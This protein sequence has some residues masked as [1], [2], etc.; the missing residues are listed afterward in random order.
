MTV[1]RLS[2]VL[3]LVVAVSGVAAG[4]GTGGESAARAAVRADGVRP[5]QGGGGRGARAAARAAQDPAAAN[6]QALAR[7]VRQAFNGVVRRELDLNDQKWRQ[8]QTVERRYQ[9]QKAQVQRDEKDARVGLKAAME[10]T[11]RTGGADQARISQYLDQLVQAQHRRAEL[12]DAEQKDLAS[13]LTPLQ[14]AK[15]QAL[16]EQ[17]NSRVQAIR[18]GAAPGAPPPQP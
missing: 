3:G 10:D 5:R 12:L 6:R 18:R 13:F 8:L 17:L 11:A 2:V 7:Q 1:S 16:R 4:Q 9:Q 14:R 15:Y